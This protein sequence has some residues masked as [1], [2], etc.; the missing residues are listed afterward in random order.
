[1]KLI[2]L[3]GEIDAQH[4]LLVQPPQ[5]VPPGAIEVALIVPDLLE[6]EAEDSW[7]AGISHEWADE[8]ADERQDI[9]TLAHGDAVDGSR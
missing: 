5:T 2:K 3:H 9:Y 8:L 1:M 4:R 6:D 7:S